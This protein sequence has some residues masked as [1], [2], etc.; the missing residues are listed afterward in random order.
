MIKT[1]AIEVLTRAIKN[2]AQRTIVLI[3]GITLKNSD[4]VDRLEPAWVVQ[5]IAGF[6]QI[7][8]HGF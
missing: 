3:Q 1:I 7:I 4:A 6:N 5:K 2:L 8:I